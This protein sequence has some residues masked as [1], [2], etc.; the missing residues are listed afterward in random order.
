MPQTSFIFEPND[1]FVRLSETDWF[2]I[3]R[4]ALNSESLDA[5]ASDITF[6]DDGRFVAVT[7]EGDLTPDQHAY[8]QRNIEQKLPLKLVRHAN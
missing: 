2:D 3:N 8:V 7:F 6:S 5:G 1:P 4:Y